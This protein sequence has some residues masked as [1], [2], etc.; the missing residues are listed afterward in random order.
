MKYFTIKELCKSQT[1]TSHGIDNVPNQLQVENMTKL[2]EVILDKVREAYGRAINITS[3]FRCPALNDIVGGVN[4]SHHL[5]GKAADIDVGSQ[6]DNKKLY[7]L[8]KSL[9]LPVCQCIL[10]HGGR[11]IHISYDE[12]DIRKQYFNI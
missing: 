10:E 5:Y 2:I 1:A 4:T 9:D 11:W 6:S 3:G 7:D 8:I 12:N